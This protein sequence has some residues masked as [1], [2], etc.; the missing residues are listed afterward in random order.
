[1]QGISLD[2]EV[3]DVSADVACWLQPPGQRELAALAGVRG[4]QELMLELCLQRKRHG[5]LAPVEQ[6]SEAA[7]GDHDVG[8]GVRPSRHDC[9]RLLVRL[10]IKSEL[11]HTDRLAS[12][13][14]GSKNPESIRVLHDLDVLL[15]ERTT[16]RCAGQ[17]HCLSA[18]A[19]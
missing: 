3:E 1:M 17:G 11:Q 13:R 12:T 5:T 8:K 15:R 14:H 7:V 19:A 9:E 2:A 18:L 6:V 10:G 4:G 16:M